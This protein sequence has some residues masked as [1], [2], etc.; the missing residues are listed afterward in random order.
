MIQFSVLS[1]FLGPFTKYAIFMVYYL[2]AFIAFVV[3]IVTIKKVDKF[4]YIPIFFTVISIIFT[5]YMFLLN[6]LW[7]KDLS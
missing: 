1:L 4:K 5:L 7:G 3:F 2:V 6:N